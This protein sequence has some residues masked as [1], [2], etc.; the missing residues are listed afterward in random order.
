MGFGLRQLLA[1]TL[2]V[3][4]ASSAA[5]AASWQDKLS[6][7]ASDLMGSSSSA[8]QSEGLSLQ[9]LTGLLNSNSQSLASG[10]IKNAAGVLDYCTK[11]NVVGDNSSSLVSQLKSKLGLSINS[12][13]SQQNPYIE[14]AKGLLTMADN[15]KL[16]LKSLGNSQL[17]EKLKTK[18]CNIVLEQGKRYL[19]K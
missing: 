9:S 2:S 18:A 8:G 6:S 3:G 4:L 5:M 16:D 13:S 7:T 12:S 1:V 11:H 15:K 10:N 19:A 14:G 17:G